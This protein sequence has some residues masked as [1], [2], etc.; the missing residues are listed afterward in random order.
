VQ[1]D[2]RLGG[3]G[4]PVRSAADPGARAATWLGLP[5]TTGAVLP[6][7]RVL[8][9]VAGAL[10]F[11]VVADLVTNTGLH[12]GIMDDSSKLN[13][14]NMIPKVSLLRLRSRCLC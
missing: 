7:L 3:Q 13:A 14:A 1:G 5:C 10:P 8:A 9:M 6:W 12:L 2:V 11:F 4:R